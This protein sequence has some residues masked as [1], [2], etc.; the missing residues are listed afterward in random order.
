MEGD[1]RCLIMIQQLSI[2]RPLTFPGAEKVIPTRCV[3]LFHCQNKCVD[4]EQ[5]S[6][7]SQC[8]IA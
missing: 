7:D 3:V 6:T 8:D 1:L 5:T 2:E 4:S